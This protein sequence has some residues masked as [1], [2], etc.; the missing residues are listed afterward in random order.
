MNDL[1]ILGVLYPF[2]GHPVH[3]RARTLYYTFGGWWV[4]NSTHFSPHSDQVLTW[5]HIVWPTLPK[6]VYLRLAFFR[7]NLTEIV[8]KRS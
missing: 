3:K 5:K 7:E 4:Q 8:K 6:T 1:C 2:L